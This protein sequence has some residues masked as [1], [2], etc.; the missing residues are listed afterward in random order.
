MPN[1]N[2]FQDFH[3]TFTSVITG[4]FLGT[5]YPLA[6]VLSYKNSSPTYHNF[7][8]TTSSKTEPNSFKEAS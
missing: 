2:D 7:I 6:F 1:I 5:R 8:I 3:T 4:Q